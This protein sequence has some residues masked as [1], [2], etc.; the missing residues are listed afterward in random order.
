LSKALQTNDPDIPTS[1]IV[2]IL[3]AKILKKK[4]L[5]KKQI[6]VS[7]LTMI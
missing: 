7:G 2:N 4:N 6:I 1:E 5:R 3:A